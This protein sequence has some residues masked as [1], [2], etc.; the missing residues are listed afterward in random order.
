[1]EKV[2][3]MNGEMNVERVISRKSEKCVGFGKGKEHCAKLY[4]CA[5]SNATMCV[6][7]R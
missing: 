3:V 4:K 5:G 2:N 6:D 1:M 7:M